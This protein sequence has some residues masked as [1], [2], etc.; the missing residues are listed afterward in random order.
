FLYSGEFRLGAKKFLA[1]YNIEA[2]AAAQGELAPYT[3][4]C[5]PLVSSGFR[6]TLTAEGPL[7]PRGS[8]L[9]VPADR[10]LLPAV[11]AQAAWQSDSIELILE[12]MADGKRYIFMVI[13]V[14]FDVVT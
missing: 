14:T 12:S 1:H 3:V 9:M 2:T 8:T 10:V 5:G 6:F 13:G 7:G 4:P 11:F